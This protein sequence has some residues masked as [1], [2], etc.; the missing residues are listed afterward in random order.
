MTENQEIIDL[1]L[2]LLRKERNRLLKI[3]D[4][5]MIQD[6][7][8][9]SADKKNE[10]VNYRKALRDLPSTVTTININSTYTEISGFTWP[11][12]PS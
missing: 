5:Y 3:T 1:K 2:F 9:S 11:V 6:Y 7:P 4:I 12:S 8:H 10:W